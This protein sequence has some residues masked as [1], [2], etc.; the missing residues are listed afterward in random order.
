MK[1]SNKTFI[2]LILFGGEIELL[3]VIQVYGSL[4]RD[5]NTDNVFVKKFL[6]TTVLLFKQTVGNK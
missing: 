1:H 2:S 3:V 4:L 5:L 6:N